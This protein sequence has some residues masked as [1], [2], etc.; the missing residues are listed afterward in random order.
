MYYSGLHQNKTQ[1]YLDTGKRYIDIEVS[2]QGK[3][4]GG[5]ETKVGASRY[6][7]LQRLKDWYLY[8]AKKY[9]VDL[10]R[11]PANW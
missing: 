4:L 8:T 7:T 2:F 9:R 3:L 5:I 11:K 6:K 1:L 10:V